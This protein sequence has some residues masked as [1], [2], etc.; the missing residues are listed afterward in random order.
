MNA[1]TFRLAPVAL[2]H[3]THNAGG[4]LPPLQLTDICPRA[5]TGHGSG[6]TSSCDIYCC[7]VNG[8]Q[9]IGT[10]PYKSVM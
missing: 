10:E 7:V 6:E 4:D 1:G 3:P 9:H 2:H 5:R 8:T